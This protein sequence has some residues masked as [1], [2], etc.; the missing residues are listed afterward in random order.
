MRELGLLSLEEAVRKMTFLPAANLG[1]SDRG[2]LAEGMAADIVIFDPATIADRS[3]WDN[4]GSPKA[5][6]TS[7]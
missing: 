7:S 3:T 6:S 1:L 4:T 2:R 5:W